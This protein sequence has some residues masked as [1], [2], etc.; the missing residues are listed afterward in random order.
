MAAPSYTAHAKSGPI[1]RV[2]LTTDAVMHRR[3]FTTSN[4]TPAQCGPRSPLGEALHVRRSN[5]FFPRLPQRGV[6]LGL[7]QD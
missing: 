3:Q 7:R 6:D 4:Y 1:S 2:D 5:A